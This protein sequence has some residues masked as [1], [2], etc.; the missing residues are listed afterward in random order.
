MRSRA[1]ERHLGGFS[2]GGIKP[3]HLL[4]NRFR[5]AELSSALHCTLRQEEVFRPQCGGA[6][7]LPQG[8]PGQSLVKCNAVLHACEWRERNERPHHR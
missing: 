5:I 8:A 6:Q 2:P 3:N 7:L 4:A 1:G